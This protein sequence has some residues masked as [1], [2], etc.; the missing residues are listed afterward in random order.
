MLCHVMDQKH[1]R[2]VTW[3]ANG[4]LHR[5]QEVEVVL[6][7]QNLAICLISDSLHKV[8]LHKDKKI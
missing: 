4:H 5:K 2:I 7:K 3:N 6:N 8:I 1:L